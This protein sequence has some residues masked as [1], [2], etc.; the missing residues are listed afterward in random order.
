[1]QGDMVMDYNPL[2]INLIIFMVVLWIALVLLLSFYIWRAQNAEHDK[3][4]NE[5]DK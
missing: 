5:R 3:I 1:M 4:R 2:F